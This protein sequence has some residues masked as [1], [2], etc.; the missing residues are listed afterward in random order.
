MAQAQ[1]HIS[2]RAGRFAG[3]VQARD[4]QLVFISP[5]GRE[6]LSLRYTGSE[7]LREMAA[8]PPSVVLE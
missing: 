7:V 4:Y 3:Q 2:A 5:Q 1:L 6:R 8:I